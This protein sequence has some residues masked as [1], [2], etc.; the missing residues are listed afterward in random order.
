MNRMSLDLA[1]E[2]SYSFTNKQHCTKRLQSSISHYN[3]ALPP[4]NGRKNKIKSTVKAT[5]QLHAL[6]FITLFKTQSGFISVLSDIVRETD[7]RPTTLYALRRQ[8]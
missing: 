2:L 4:Q 8:N 7:G 6:G 3:R 1:S 5:R